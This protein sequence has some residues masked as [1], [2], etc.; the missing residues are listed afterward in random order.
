MG[1]LK[2]VKTIFTAD[3]HEAL[4]RMENPIS[5]MNQYMRNLEEQVGDAQKALAHQ[6][7]LEKRYEIL[8]N[9]AEA[10]VAKRSRQA[11]LAV[12]RNEEDMARL[13]LKEK[14]LEE[15]KLT[16]YR[17]QFS[18]IKEQTSRLYE[19]ISKLNEKYQELEYKKLSLLTRAHAAK[20]IKQSHS[21]LSN[22]DTAS[23]VR[24]FAKVEGYVQKLEAEAAASTHFYQLSTGTKSAAI[25]TDLLDAI[26]KELAKLKE[27]Q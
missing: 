15:E 20:A 9:E 1:I 8:V 26:D 6:L 5:M 25:Q 16:A 10:L 13:A 18:A 4:D 22:F 3:V 14:I 11:E 17:E 27:A 12:S 7:Y 21:A 24:G 19:Q 2:R 23:A